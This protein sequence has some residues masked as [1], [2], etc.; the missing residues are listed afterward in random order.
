MECVSDEEQEYDIWKVFIQFVVKLPYVSIFLFV[1]NLLH[2]FS[3][4]NVVNSQ[5]YSV[6]L[7]SSEKLTVNETFGIA[8]LLSKEMETKLW[9]S[10]YSLAR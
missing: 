4:C 10:H 6:S 9:E 1:V 3:I 5:K 7:S 2:S 8:H